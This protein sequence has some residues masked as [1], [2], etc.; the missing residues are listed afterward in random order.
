L[1]KTSAKTLASAFGDDTEDWRGRE[2]VLFEAMVD[3]QGKTVATIWCMAAPKAADL[4]DEIP[5]WAR[6]ARTQC[7]TLK[8]LRDS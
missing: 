2:I 8:N 4:D 3:F 1:N 5:F 7:S 6:R